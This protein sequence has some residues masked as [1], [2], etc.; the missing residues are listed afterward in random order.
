LT[1]EELPPYTAEVLS[2]PTHL[3]PYVYFL[4]TPGLPEVCQPGTPLTFRNVAVY[5]VG[6]GDG[7]DLDRW[8]GTGG[9]GYTLTAEAGVL[10][11]S[12]GEIY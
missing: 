7:F 9:I 12:R 6:P 10:T 8:R 5:R 11:S 3:T 1:A 2:T 4:S